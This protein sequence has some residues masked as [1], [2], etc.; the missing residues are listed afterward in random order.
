MLMNPLPTLE[1]ACSLLQ[2]EELQRELTQ[3]T[4]FSMQVTALYSMENLK[5]KCSI[6]GFKWHPPERCWEKICYPNWHPKFKQSKLKGKDGN[7][8]KGYSVMKGNQ[9]NRKVAASK[10]CLLVAA[11]LLINYWI[12]DT[13]STDHMTPILKNLID[14]AKLLFKPKINLPNGL[15][16]VITHTWTIKLNNELVLKNT[17]HSFKFSLHIAANPVFHARTKHIKVDCHFVRDQINAG[18]VKPSYVNTKLQ[19]ADLFDIASSLSSYSLGLGL[20]ISLGLGCRLVPSCCVIFDLK[21]L[22]LFIIR[23]S[24]TG[25]LDLSVRSSDADALDSANLIVLLTG[26]LKAGFLINSIATIKTLT[27]N[28][29]VAILLIELSIHLLDQ[30]RYL[31]D[32]SLIHIESRKSPTAVMFDD[33]TGRISIRHCEILKSITLNVLA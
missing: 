21:P 15:T 28:Q 11:S 19:L 2:Q 16:F 9:S 22:S 6:C 5:D 12:F 14:A 26:H 17:L 13:R 30:N 32:T 33:D 4:S 7:G 29:L 25:F 23:T 1:S 31:V 20:G 10:F 27:V 3:N 18:I 24:L 8:F